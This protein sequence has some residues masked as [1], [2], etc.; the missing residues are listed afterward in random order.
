MFPL[1]P[2]PAGF[3]LE[4]CV[5]RESTCDPSSNPETDTNRVE[6]MIE[7]DDVSLPASNDGSEVEEIF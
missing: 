6:L 5:I 7:E 1:P 3:E 2:S 4:V